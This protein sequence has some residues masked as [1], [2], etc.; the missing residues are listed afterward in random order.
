MTAGKSEDNG[1]IKPSS[2]TITNSLPASNRSPITCI[3]KDSSLEFTV[4]PEPTPAMEDLEVMDSKKLMPKPTLSGGN[5][6]FI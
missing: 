3:P 1:Q 6:C 5:L 4:M 2:L